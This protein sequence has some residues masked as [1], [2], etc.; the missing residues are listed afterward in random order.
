[1][2]FSND[3]RTRRFSFFLPKKKNKKRDTMSCCVFDFLYLLFLFSRFKR[4]LNVYIYELPNKW[5][6]LEIL[7]PAFS[8]CNHDGC[9]FFVRGSQN[10]KY[11]PWWIDDRSTGSVSSSGWNLTREIEETVKETPGMFRQDATRRKFRDFVI[12]I[13]G[14]D[15]RVWWLARETFLIRLPVWLAR[16]SFPTPG[17][18]RVNQAIA[19][20]HLL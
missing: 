11:Y 4:T 3:F 2:Y 19:S 13:V 10:G 9:F 18:L 14:T 5:D 16:G 6:R 20:R 17:K 12:F 1:M 7:R 8:P 15:I